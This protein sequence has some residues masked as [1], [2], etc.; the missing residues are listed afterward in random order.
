MNCDGASAG[1]VCHQ[2]DGPTCS[3]RG[4]LTE[5]VDD[6]AHRSV[7]C[8]KDF[9]MA[10]GRATR[11][12]KPHICPGSKPARADAPFCAVVAED[13]DRSSV[14]AICVAPSGQM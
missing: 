12:S 11:R 13:F 10:A 4:S 6:A 3:S 9:G 7:I 5:S 14:C 8:E 1:K 2:M